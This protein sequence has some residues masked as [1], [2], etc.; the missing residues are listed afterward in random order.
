MRELGLRP[1]QR[2]F[3]DVLRAHDGDDF[4]LV[5]CPAAGKTIGAGAAV[6]PVMQARGCDQL[7]VVCPTV[8]VRNQWADEL[9]Q[10]GYVMRRTFLRHRGG[11]PPSAHG[12]CTTYAQVAWRAAEY[13]A[14]CRNR[15]TVVI[16]DEV[17]HAADDRTWGGSLQTAFGDAALRLALSGTPFRSDRGRLPYVNYGP[18]GRCTADFAYDYPRAV[19]DGLCRPARFHAHGGVV[20]WTEGETERSAG[21]AQR[22]DLPAQGRRLR[23]SLDPSKP[24]LRTML[25]AAHHDLQE[26]RAGK[27]SSDAGGLIVCDSQEHARAIATLM[28]DLTGRRPVLAI[29][30]NPLA[31]HAIRAFAS[32]EQPWL[33]AVRM[34]AE[35]VDIPRLRVIAW[36]T[37][38]RTE[39]M[40]R[41]VIGRA[42][43]TTVYDRTSPAIVHMPADPE[44]VAHA[45]RLH[46]PGGEGIR[47]VD[48]HR[49]GPSG[50][51]DH[52][53]RPRLP[54]AVDAQPSRAGGPREINP[55]LPAPRAVTAA[56]EPVTIDP[57]DPPEPKWQGAPVEADRAALRDDARNELFRLVCIY[58]QLRRSIDPAYPLAAAQREL[59]AELGDHD[60]AEATDA[61][62]AHGLEWVRG[63]LAELAAT[64][65]DHVRELARAR[66][67]LRAA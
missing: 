40:V 37:A 47:E 64:H 61:Q 10:L 25:Q 27:T 6:A 45:E 4:L 12:I 65:P 30:D 18:D 44:L 67:R 54:D 16:F 38:S 63:E 41:Q 5:A 58:A 46:G 2:A 28:E 7:I 49:G 8:V 1:W 14:A 32:G 29:S 66:R 9:E 36:A 55:H 42:L 23:A 26:I 57:P 50:R 13:A 43:R 35:G 24:Y 33:V 52:G 56:T 53:S 20:T 3:S 22:L 17:H 39:L 34:V 51:G 19:V 59:R 21:F 31:H 11:W 62:V 60:R 48:R 15:R